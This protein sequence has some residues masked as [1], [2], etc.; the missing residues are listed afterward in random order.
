MA[1]R[2]EGQPNSTTHMEPDLELTDN[3]E[4]IGASNTGTNIERAYMG[5]LSSLLKWHEEDP[6]DQIER[7][8]NDTIAKFQGNRNP[9]I[10][11]PEYVSIIFGGARA[12]AQSN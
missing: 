5:R 12:E 6:V 8:R 7:R 1:V 4:L 11:H 2:Y 9:F 10:D 3:L